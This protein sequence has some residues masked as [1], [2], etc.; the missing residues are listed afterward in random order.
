MGRLT[1]LK[2]CAVAPGPPAPA[3]EEPVP[4]NPVPAPVVV[5]EPLCRTCAVSHIANGHTDGQEVIL[6]GFGGWLREL[7]FPVARCTD[8][9]ERS[10]RSAGTAGFGCAG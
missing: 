5:S 8:Y 3:T 7:P 9:R 2:L 1:I 6:C 4:G 10:K